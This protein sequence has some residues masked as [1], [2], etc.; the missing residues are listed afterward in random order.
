MASGSGTCTVTVTWAASSNYQGAVATRSTAAAKVN[1]TTAITSFGPNPAVAGQQVTVGFTASSAVPLA[2]GLPGPT[3]TVTVS[4]GGLSCTGALNA[5]AGS[6][7]LSFPASGAKTLRATYAG[8]ANFNAS[9]PSASVTEQIRDFAIA[10]A[11]ATQSVNGNQSAKYTVTVTSQNGFTGS[12]AV[13][14]GGGYPSSFACSVSAPTVTL[15]A[16][17]SATATVTVAPAKG[18][19]GTYTVTATGKYGSGAP[20]SG[21]LTHSVNTSLTTKT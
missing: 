2:G 8:D 21:G 20:A 19:P 15:T 11:P 1:S 9:P 17:G 5:G 12:V 13:T 3:G 7:A 4:G 18:S 10:I 14:C 6:C 16:N